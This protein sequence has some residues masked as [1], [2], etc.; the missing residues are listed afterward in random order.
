MD[1]LCAPQHT[2]VVFGACLDV[3]RSWGAAVVYCSHAGSAA[4]ARLMRI[5]FARRTS[6]SRLMAKAKITDERALRLLRDRRNWF[7]TAGDSDADRPSK[8][9]E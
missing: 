4:P 2:A 5:G 6:G 8:D 9:V 7:V 1:F 3:F